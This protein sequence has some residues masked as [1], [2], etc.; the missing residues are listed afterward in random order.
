MNSPC[1][2]TP[3]HISD[4]NI[5]PGAKPGL[6]G[7]AQRAPGSIVA[8]LSD[9]AVMQPTLVS[10]ALS[11]CHFLGMNIGSFTAISGGM[12]LRNNRLMTTLLLLAA[13]HPPHKQRLTLRGSAHGILRIKFVLSFCSRCY[14]IPHC[15]M[16]RDLGSGRHRRAPDHFRSRSCMGSAGMDACCI[17]ATLHG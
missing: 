3:D 5:S 8:Q 2:T 12:A 10:M 11:P 9:R 7:G 1:T 16:N 13:P 15:S 6:F 4:R 14:E 17:L